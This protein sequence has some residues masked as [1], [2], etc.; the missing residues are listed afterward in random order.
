MQMAS[1]AR[2][3]GRATA[4]IFPCDGLQCQES[5]GNENRDQRRGIT[6]GIHQAEGKQEAIE[7]DGTVQQ[8]AVGKRDWG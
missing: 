2:P 7:I 4:Q 3:L 8:Y 1:S 6:D 5:I